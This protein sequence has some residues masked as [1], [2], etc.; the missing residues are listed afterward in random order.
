MAY[1]NPNPNSYQIVDGN[2]IKITESDGNGCVPTRTPGRGQ[3]Q[4]AHK[5]AH[6]HWFSKIGT[7]LAVKY[8]GKDHCKHGP[9]K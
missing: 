5:R 4:L 3:Y 8:L 1:M 6:D 9:F 2:H 7:E